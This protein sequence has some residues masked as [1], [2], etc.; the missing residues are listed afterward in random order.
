ML[1]DIP[2]MKGETPL[3][4]PHL[5][6]NES[7]TIAKDCQFDRGVIAPTNTNLLSFSMPEEPTTI[8]KYNDKWLYWNVLT[9]A[10]KSPIAQD[11]YDRIYWTGEDKPKV[12]AQD[13]ALGSNG[14][15][16]AASYDL[17]V[18]APESAPVVTNID[19]ST[20]DDPEEGELDSYDD[21]DRVYIQTYVTRFGEEGAPG[22]P[23]DTVVIEKPGSTVTIDLVQPGANTHNITHTRLYRSVTS[24]S[25]SDYILVAELPISQEEYID[26]EKNVSGA[27]LE[28]YDY[29]V[30]DSDM[31]GLCMMANGIAAGFAGNEVMFSEAYLPY[32]WPSSYRLTTEHEIVSIA[33]IG[34]SLVAATKGYPYLFSGVSPGSI[35]GTKLNVEQAC[36]SAQSM[37]VLNGMVFYASPDGLI[38][39]SSDGAV[40]ATD[41]LITR[42]Q[43]Q[44]LKPESIKAVAV[45]GKYVAQAEGNAF[46]FDPTSQDIVYISDQWQCS[47]NDLE[48]DRLYI[49]DGKTVYEWRKGDELNAFEWQSKEFLLT[50][51]TSLSSARIHADEPEK[52]SV[53]I[54]ADNSDIITIA[55]GSLTNQSFRLPAVRAARWK[56]K[57][58]G[59]SGVDRILVG[60]NM[61]ELV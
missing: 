37:V 61:Q 60:S 23:S 1:I 11:P 54:I 29:D 27:T 7:A 38:V 55:E 30:P 44:A 15:G 24:S 39:V 21:E 6:S 58:T 35:T 41:Q 28:T 31:S 13:I 51:N 43:W 12:T 53:T 4:K 25:E 18:P 52:L 10:I 56:V 9:D 34:N 48:S 33:S 17:G 36:V 45:E 26:S 22:D 57:I 20:G 47:F 50:I 49:A 46:I 19:T 59:T 14:Y 42:V 16:P 5:L 32:A 3:L 8:F 40:N 2:L